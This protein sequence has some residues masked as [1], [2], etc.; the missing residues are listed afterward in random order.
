MGMRILKGTA[1]HRICLG[2]V[3]D[4]ML[5]VR[6]KLHRVGRLAPPSPQSYVYLNAARVS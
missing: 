1:T 6:E 5:G 2:S 4:G 3:T